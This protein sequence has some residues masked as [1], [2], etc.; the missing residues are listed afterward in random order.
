MISELFKP[1]I[2]LFLGRGLLI[3]LQIAVTT[4]ILSTFFGT[5]VG[6]A[7]Y[8]KHRILST[9]ATIYIESVRNTPLLLFILAV[10]FMTPL[11]PVMAGTLA[12][13]LFTTAI[14]A[15]IVRGGLNSI[16]KGQWEAARSQGFGYATTMIYIILPQAMRNMIPPMVSQFITVIK[17]TSFVWVVGIEDLTGKG[18]IIMGKYS[19]SAQVFT[20]FGMIAATYFIL[21]YGLSLA[22]RKQQ[23]RM[24]HQGA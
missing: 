23:K 3:T 8:S 5:I 15:E 1:A 4:I 7:R 22:A 17:D 13:T 18:M 12:M 14:I 16:S 6:I 10:R 21:N 24:I 11:K 20:L 19:S 2:F 9:L